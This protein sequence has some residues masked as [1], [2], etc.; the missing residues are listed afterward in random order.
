MKKS[1]F[2]VAMLGTLLLAGQT[3][4]NAQEAQQ[5]GVYI[6][7]T[8]GYYF[9][10]ED[11][12]NNT[13]DSMLYGLS[14]GYQINKNFAVELNYSG[15]EPE[16]DDTTFDFDGK[17]Q[18]QGDEVDVDLI[19]LDGIFNLDLSSPW[20]PYLAVGYTRLEQDPAFSDESDEEDMMDLGFG[21]R[22]AI[23]PSLSLKADMR[24]FHN[25][26]N[27]DTD[28]AVQ[29]GL[30]YLFGSAPAPAP[31]Q[32]FKPVDKTPDPVDPC[33]L[34]D[35]KDGVNN[36]DDVCPDTP[37]GSTVETTGCRL[38]EVPEEIRLEILFDFDKAQVKPE[39]FGEIRRVVDF[40]NKY[41]STA[42]EIQGHTDS[43]GTDEY[44]LD[45]S[46]QRASAVLDV[47]INEFGLDSSRLRAVGYGEARPIADN[48][49]RTNR[50]LNRRVIA[51]IETVV[52]KVEEK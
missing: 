5:N 44:N 43:M 36:C 17:L 29:L 30:Q 13:K 49:T 28:Y 10:D 19:R 2:S 37:I 7:P 42:T 27:E 47:L 9:F 32:T 41:P 38:L 14:V 40:M 39:Y 24:A 51:Y 31:I 21:I 50:Q 45:L 16:V 18:N 4:V 33:S 1:N 12:D 3:V 15:L 20:S 34:D 25:F 11:D 46:Q 8:I 48:D 26:D 23:T 6:A 35:D 22:R 52:K